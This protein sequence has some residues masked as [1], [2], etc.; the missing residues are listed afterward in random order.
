M[1][2]A[3]PASHNRVKPPL[4][5]FVKFQIAVFFFYSLYIKLVNINQ[6]HLLLLPAYTASSAFC[7]LFD[8]GN[9]KSLSEIKICS[10][11][12]SY[13]EAYLN[14]GTVVY[15]QHLFLLISWLILPFLPKYSVSSEYL[16]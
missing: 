9:I 14:R 7:L 12:S 5:I 15:S 16:L 2:I 3:F 10:P 8:V 1:K 13:W 4:V 11:C 6:R